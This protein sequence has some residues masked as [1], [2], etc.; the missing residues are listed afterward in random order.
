MKPLHRSFFAVLGLMIVAGCASKPMEVDRITPISATNGS[1]SLDLYAKQ[2]NAGEAVP[3]FAGDQIVDV[4]TYTATKNGGRGKEF[5]GA[6]CKVEARDFTAS[7]ISPAKVRVPN[8]R[9]KSSDLSV[10]CEHPDYKSKLVTTG[11]YNQ[12]KSD[13]LNAGSHAGLAGLALMAVVNGVSDDSKD[14]YSYAPI[15]VVMRPLK[16]VVQ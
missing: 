3:E 2:R 10:R 1:S 4:R 9:A 8:F 6:K 15:L 11:V 7:T 14:I 12:T 13:R 16:P 5:A